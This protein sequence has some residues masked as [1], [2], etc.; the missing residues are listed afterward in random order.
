MLRHVT[1]PV[2]E[3]MR[4]G[5]GTHLD[6][7]LWRLALS[8]A[9]ERDRELQQAIRRAVHCEDAPLYVMP[10]SV[11]SMATPG[12]GPTGTF[13]RRHSARPAPVCDERVR[14]RQRPVERSLL[15]R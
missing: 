12:R 9:V 14:Y 6:E 15:V 2:A 10:S 4:E 13:G 8:I 7:M 5:L 3:K 1:T 11:A